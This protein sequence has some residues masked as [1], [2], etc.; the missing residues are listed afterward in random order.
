[1]GGDF[2]NDE[3]PNYQT[4]VAD[5]C[6]GE[7]EVTVGQ[8]KKCVQAGECKPARRSRFSCNA[9]FSDREDHPINC[10]DHHQ[11]SA[12][13]EFVGGRLPSELEW[14]YA[15]RGGSEQRRYSWGDEHPD[16]RSCWKQAAGTCKVKSFAPGAF[17]LHDMTGNLWE[18]TSDWF[19]SYPWP[20]L[21]G[22]AKI[23]KGGSWSRRFVKWMRPALRNRYGPH[24]WGSHL[25]FRCA[26]TP[27]GV[28]CPFGHDEQGQC[29]HGVLSAECSPGKVFNNMRCAE[30]GAPPCKPGYGENPGHGCVASAPSTGQQQQNQ[31]ITQGVSRARSPEFDGDCRKHYLGRPNAYRYAGGTHAGRNQVSQNAGCKN[32]DVGAGFNSCCCP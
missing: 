8:Y 31:V 22:H 7:T 11:A 18:W 16:G 1:V 28:D 15:A 21:E 27:A 10:V 20:R 19:G 6:L 9:R 29:R 4:K 26:K 5:F 2:N 17:G 32:R 30:P 3:K 25:G 13:C 24:E 12:Y 14:E 23:Y